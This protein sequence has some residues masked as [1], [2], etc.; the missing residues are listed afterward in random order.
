MN[1]QDAGRGELIVDNNKSLIGLAGNPNYYVN[2]SLNDWEPV[3]YE[4]GRITVTN[5]GVLI[6]TSNATIIATN[7]VFCGD[8]TSVHDGI[9]LVGG[10]MIVPDDF[11]FSNFFI[12]IARHWVSRNYN[13]GGVVIDIDSDF[14]PKKSLTIGENAAFVV[15]QPYILTNE[16]VVEAGGS[17]SHDFNCALASYLRQ[18]VYGLKLTVCGNVLI[19]EGGSI[20]V[21]GKGYVGASGPGVHWVNAS[22]AS[23]GGL[24]S[25]GLECYGSIVAPTNLGSGGRGDN[26]YR[27]GGLVQM[28]VS[29]MLRNEG[30][31]RANAFE[32]TLNTGSG[33]AIL[34]TAGRLAGSGVI[35]ANSATNVTGSNPGGG[36][37]ISLTVTNAGAD[38]SEYTGTIT[39]YGGRKMPSGTSG[40]AGTIYLR[41]AGQGLY[42]GALFL[43]NGEMPGLGTEISA[44]V[45]D[46][47]VG[48]VFIQSGACLL[49]NTNQTLT[50]GGDWHNSASFTS[51][52]DSAVIFAGAPAHLQR[53]WLHHF[54][55]VHLHQR[56]GGTIRFRAVL[57]RSLRGRLFLS[58]SGATNLIR[59]PS[60]TVFLASE[61]RPA[62]QPRPR[63]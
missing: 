8:P 5:N 28:T 26:T 27:G 56:L 48:D 54:F 31:I 59:V 36:G 57:N 13:T 46:T 2:T 53:L 61:R 49:L 11:A 34:M 63:I 24:G 37:R 29:G 7:T 33:G 62:E 38:F 15:D 32:R 9:Q 22:G 51:L 10:S 43:N 42:E 60:P 6:L 4:F 18:E 50:I 16:V 19:R 25:G 21:S 52:T 12:R 41:E 30:A 3:T 20:D 23:Y 44:S 40:G 58:A 35:E 1:G 47:A 39:S 55:R 45:T 17:I 14:R